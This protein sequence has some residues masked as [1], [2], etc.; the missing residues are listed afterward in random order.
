[1]KPGQPDWKSIAEK[2]CFGTVLTSFLQ[3]WTG[4]EL[5]MGR[6]LPSSPP[7]PL[8]PHTHVFANLALP[9]SN[10]RATFDRSNSQ[11]FRRDCRIQFYPGLLS[12][13]LLTARSQKMTLACMGTRQSAEAFGYKCT[14]SCKRMSGL[15]TDLNHQ[16]N[17]GKTH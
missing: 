4:T 17:L 13:A 8:P 15:Q 6:L 10:H 9:T 5:G 3:G 1:M 12:R 7:P 11:I 16:Q 14:C 2:D